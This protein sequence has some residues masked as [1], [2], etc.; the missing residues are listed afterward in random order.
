VEVFPDSAHWPFVD[1]AAKTR[2]LVVPFLRPQLSATL[3][4]I[5]RTR[6]RVRVKV[7][8]P[9]PA[10]RVTAALGGSTTKPQAVS[11]KRTLAIRLGRPLGAGF[12]TVTVRA[13]GL[14]ARR[15]K[16]RVAAARRTASGH[17]DPPDRRDR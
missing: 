4:R 7:T 15:L 6:V 13:F 8:G 12:H 1:N 2:G 17:R 10:E 16:L 11:G 5:G 9:L 14:P 3:G